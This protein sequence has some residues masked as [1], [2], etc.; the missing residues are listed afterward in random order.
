MASKVT[1]IN[2]QPR[3][4][5]EI[6]LGEA[7]MS[8]ILTN[9]LN[10]LSEDA[11]VYLVEWSAKSRVPRGAIIAGREVAWT[12]HGLVRQ[13]GGDIIGYYERLVD[14]LTKETQKM[15]VWVPQDGAKGSPWIRE[16][17]WL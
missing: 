11:D 14:D 4:R 5:A 16:F 2:T 6:D 3:R 15:L 1:K 9:L 13:K 8:H 7:E 17:P 12:Q 10:R